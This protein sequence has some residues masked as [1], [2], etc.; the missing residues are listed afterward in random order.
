MIDRE[1]VTSALR[2]EGLDVA[3]GENSWST[4]F[5]IEGERRQTILIYRPDSVYFVAAA[6]SK[7]RTKLVDLPAPKLVELIRA[8]TDI[9]LAKVE[10]YEFD[11]DETG[12]FVA[13]SECSVEAYSGSK[14]R[15][16][17]EACAR[18]AKRIDAIL[19]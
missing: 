16:R 13:E 15:R 2:G 19:L 12:S 10:Y 1:A 3:F 4:T 14:L 6:F 5:E 18:L 11:G 7:S 8:Q 17:L 9:S